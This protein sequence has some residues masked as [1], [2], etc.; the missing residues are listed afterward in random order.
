MS[1]LTMDR[2]DVCIEKLDPRTCYDC[3]KVAS[4]SVSL[5]VRGAGMVI[6]VGIYC[7]KCAREASKRLRST[8]PKREE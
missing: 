1:E 4:H 2:D 3:E 8:L 5:D 6:P 7:A